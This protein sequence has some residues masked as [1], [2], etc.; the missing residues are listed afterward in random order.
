MRK[1]YIIIIIIDIALIAIWDY[2]ANSIHVE[3]EESIGIL[4][5][6]PVLIIAS[7]V[8]GLVLKLMK[9]IWANVI[10]VN[11]FIA[12]TIFIGVF[13]Y[14]FWKQQHDNYQMFYFRDDNKTYNIILKLNK[15]KFQNGLTY[16]IYERLGEYGN[17][18][19]D[20]DGSYIKKNDT[21]IM[22]SD[23]GKVM[24]IFRKTLFDYPQ[25]GD[26]TVLRNSPD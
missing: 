26:L 11:V 9:G 8:V 1:Q 5:I 21:L 6:V 16:N 7:G 24:K 20:L 19:T 23:K 22:T 14:E 17:A 13:K 10:L 25:S 3:Q 4:L 18:G 2:W 12:F 15:G